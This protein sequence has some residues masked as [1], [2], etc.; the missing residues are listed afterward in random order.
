MKKY[1]F[2]ILFSLPMLVHYNILFFINCLRLNKQFYFI[3]Y[4]NNL[5]F[6][7]FINEYKKVNILEKAKLSDKLL[8][9]KTLKEEYDILVRIPPLLII[10]KNK[11]EI[12]NFDFE[13]L[14]NKEIIIKSNHGS[15]MNLIVNK[16]DV[17]SKKKLHKISDW[18]SFPS[19]YS[20]REMH[21]KLIDKKVFVE[22]LVGDNVIDY[23]LF[24]YEGTCKIIQLDFDRFDFHRRNFYSKDWELLDFEFVYKKNNCVIEK[25][26]HLDLIVG[27][28]EEI[29]KYFLFVRVD[30]YLIEDEIFLGE[31]TFHPEGGVGPFKN[32]KQDIDFL[33]Y[34]KS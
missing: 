18:F 11:E 14:M 15:G 17:L 26:I 19:H 8:L 34:L 6:N 16:N 23:K 32:K 20:S 3:F 28:S 31:L 22:E 5:T 33:N 7:N 13:K 9:V 25:P 4:G 27:M 10:F 24:C 29:S 1:F 12:I 30:W 21:Y 2:K